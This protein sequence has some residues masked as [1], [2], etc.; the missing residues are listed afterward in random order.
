MPRR[1]DVLRNIKYLPTRVGNVPHHMDE[2]PYTGDSLVL[3]VPHQMGIL[4]YIG[5]SY[6]GVGTVPHYINI[7]CFTGDS[8]IEVD[9]VPHHMDVLTKVS[10]FFYFF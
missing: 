2:L 5:D 10:H 6:I 1:M 3:T 9:T 8:Y 4:R 7:L